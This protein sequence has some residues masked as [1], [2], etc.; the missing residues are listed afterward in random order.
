MTVEKD[1]AAE[2]EFFVPTEGLELETYLRNRP[3][4][5]V[6]KLA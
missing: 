4:P 6:N 3:G 1:A 2:I 5:G